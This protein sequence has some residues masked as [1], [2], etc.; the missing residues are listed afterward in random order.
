MI[1]FLVGIIF[2]YR[3]KYVIRGAKR[4]PIQITEIENVNYEH[5]T[6]LTTYII[7]LIC[8]DLSQVRYAID[9]GIL[10]IIIGAI[11][12]KTNMFYANPTL[13]LLGYQIYRANTSQKQG[14]IFISKE[15]LVKGDWVQPLSLDEKIY[16]VKIKNNE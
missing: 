12:V 1:F 11:Y 5:L 14:L 6:F 7:P 4:L 13:A 2:Y 3:F 10:L 9:L 8:F 16:F 15:K